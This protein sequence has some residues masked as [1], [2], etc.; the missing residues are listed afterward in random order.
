MKYK[1]RPRKNHSQEFQIDGFIGLVIGKWFLLG[2][3]TGQL[4]HYG[5]VILDFFIGVEGIE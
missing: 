2:L 4:D 3:A 1:F 5:L